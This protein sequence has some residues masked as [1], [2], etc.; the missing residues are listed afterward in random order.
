[1][2]RQSKLDNDNAMQDK[3]GIRMNLSI[4]S[5]RGN[6]I[7]A[8][9]IDGVRPNILERIIKLLETE[10]GH[11]HRYQIAKL[12]HET[13]ESR[14]SRRFAFVFSIGTLV[15]TAYCATIDQPVV[16]TL[17]SGSGAAILMNFGI[18]RINKR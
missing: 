5:N 11:I 1:M 15:V 12:K 2:N 14:Q 6:A 7:V 16:A 10:E 18:N 9:G 8:T 13:S 3:V 4:P 17:V